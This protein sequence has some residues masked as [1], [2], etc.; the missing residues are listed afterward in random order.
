MATMQ[1]IVNRI[2]TELRFGSGLDVQIHLQASIVQNV[3]RL[4][5]S[6]MLKYDW[7]DYTLTE[8]FD[9]DANGRST[10]DFTTGTMKIN[11]FS[12]IKGIFLDGMST[13]VPVAPMMMN[14][15]MFRRP[16]IRRD[17]TGL[18]RIYPNKVYENAYIVATQMSEDDFDIT[19][20]DPIPFHDDLL[21]VGGARQLAI[22]S[23]VNDNLTKALDSEFNALVEL[24]SIQEIASSYQNN[25]ERGVYPNEWFVNE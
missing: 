9:T 1:D 14:P 15:S 23:S 25:L 21:V 3:S 17:A 10:T 7:R 12:H 16:A 18:F 8:V 19:S 20:D 22:K 24:Y 5:R 6:L 4:Y 13:P 11:R 2:T